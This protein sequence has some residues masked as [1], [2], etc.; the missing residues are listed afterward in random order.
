MS[1]YLVITGYNN[2][3]YVITRRR[4]KQMLYIHS[5]VIPVFSNLNEYY[6]AV[7]AKY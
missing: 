1:L 7:K 6:F 4:K 3:Y 2:N 5:N